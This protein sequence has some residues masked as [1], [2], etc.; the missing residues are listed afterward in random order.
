MDRPRRVHHDIDYRVTRD[1]EREKEKNNN[2]DPF[3]FNNND[4]L[5]PEIENIEEEQKKAPGGTASWLEDIDK[6]NLPSRSFYNPKKTNEELNS[7][8]KDNHIHSRDNL[9][10]DRNHSSNFTNNFRENEKDI[11]EELELEKL[12]SKRLQSELDKLKAKKDIINSKQILQYVHKISYESLGLGKKIGQGGFSEIFES[13]WMGIPV[14]VKVIFDPN[15]NEALLEEFNNEIEKLFILRHPYIIQLYG[16]TD[17]EK[18]QKLAVITELA[19]KGSLFD[20]LHK[21]SKTKNNL[22]L[23]FKNKITK[24]LVHTMAYI[25]SRG[26][27]H[28][29]LK[30]QNILLDKNLDMKLCDFGLTKLKSELNSG[31]GQFAGTPCYMAPELFDRKFYDDKVDVFAFGTVVWEIYTQKIPYF[32]CEALEIKQKVTKGEELICSSIVPKQIASL[33]EKC[34]RVKPSERPSFSDIEM[35]DLF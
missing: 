29:D 27:V 15:I 11:K 31:S 2:L 26:Y 12:K 25:H 21:N 4:E 5:N 6:L 28:R 33:I 32:N 8:E 35:M 24:Q 9:L 3:G 34:R 17:S 23:E 19:P 30:T 14:A 22:S 18:N 7:K 1:I 20:Y 10:F 13:Q 16:I